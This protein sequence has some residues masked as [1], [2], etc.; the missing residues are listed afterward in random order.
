MNVRV[1]EQDAGRFKGSLEIRKVNE[2][3]ALA[4]ENLKNQLLN[5][6]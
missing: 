5:F 2:S 3:F 1:V 6:P 4:L